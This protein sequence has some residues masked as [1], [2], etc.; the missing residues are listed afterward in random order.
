MDSQCHVSVHAQ[1]EMPPR[2]TKSR[3]D[4]L[5]ARK[6]AAA[7][8]A[9]ERTQRSVAERF[10]AAQEGKVGKG[11]TERITYLCAAA[12]RILDA[13]G[14]PE[15]F[16][17]ANADVGQ[18][19]GRSCLGTGGLHDFL[20][21]TAQ[22]AF[23]DAAVEFATGITN[24]VAIGM[25]FPPLH[26]YHPQA[27]IHLFAAT[28][29]MLAPTLRVRIVGHARTHERLMERMQ[30]ER[31]VAIQKTYGGVFDVLVARHHDDALGIHHAERAVAK[32]NATLLYA[33]PNVST[34]P[35]DFAEEFS[36]YATHGCWVRCLMLLRRRYPRQPMQEWCMTR[37]LDRMPYSPGS[38]AIIRELL[39]RA[40]PDM[41]NLWLPRVT[42]AYTGY[43]HSSEEGMLR[44]AIIQ[45]LGDDSNGVKLWPAIATGWTLDHIKRWRAIRTSVDE[46]GK[47]G[48]E[49]ER[50][51]ALVKAHNRAIEFQR[52]RAVLVH[53]A[54]H[55][56][57]PGDTVYLVRALIPLVIAY[58]DHPLESI[59]REWIPAIP[60]FAPA[61]AGI[62]RKAPCAPT[63]AAAVAST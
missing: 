12:K 53:V 27:L 15:H 20:V 45:T 44:Q 61:Y 62:K 21:P 58:L 4:A 18:R 59:P 52:Q 8:R 5:A 3:L 16:V 28:I 30:T 1:Q 41:V 50:Y 43:W 26:D 55:P 9:V 10:W 32:H 36:T 35:D 29:G 14:P 37:V 31:Y 38:V 33:G 60:D 57:S 51:V 56:S 24:D 19:V 22:T 2:R 42:Q 17:V 11:T 23:Q 48:V 40:T 49:R 6:E 34:P 46:R 13:A 7:A 47:T 63:A 39:A 25:P 54:L